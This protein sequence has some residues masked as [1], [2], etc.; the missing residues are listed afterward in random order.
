[1]TA[2]KARSVITSWS[3]LLGACSLV[4]GLAFPASAGLVT[5][6]SVLKNAYND[7]GSSPTIVNYSSITNLRANTSGSSTVRGVGQ[8][9]SCDL[10]ITADGTVYYLGGDATTTDN[11]TLFSWPS[12]AA[13]AANS[14]TTNHGT[15]TN[16][17]P[18]TGI[19]YYNNQFYVLEGSPANAGTKSLLSW[20][21]LT[22]FTS[23]SAGTT[24]GS[25][26]VGDGI[27][28]E[29]APDGTVYKLDSSPP[30]SATQGTLYS[31]PTLNDY[32]ADTNVSANGGSFTFFSGSPDQIAGLAVVPEPVVPV[33]LLMSAGLLGW[34]WRCPSRRR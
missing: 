26:L 13:W 8:N 2:V 4:A 34:A 16:Y 30:V 6:I 14:S 1:M 24:V 22:A 20:P 27:G 3:R 33:G 15:R 23:G 31:W 17:G 5:Q 32:L 12:L 21:S 11:K 9:A 10:S 18:V 19:S 7:Q 25:R 29:I 28:F